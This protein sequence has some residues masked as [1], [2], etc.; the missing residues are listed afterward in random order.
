MVNIIELQVLKHCIKS[1]IVVA[2]NTVVKSSLSI[3]VWDNWYVMLSC[4]LAIN[5]RVTDREDLDEHVF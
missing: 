2:V 3:E 5:L 1:F 4:V